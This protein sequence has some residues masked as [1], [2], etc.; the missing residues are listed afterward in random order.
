MNVVKS[1]VEAAMRNRQIVFMVT[2]LLIILG[3]FALLHMPRQEFPVFTIRQGLVIAAYP[4]ATAEQ[5]AQQLTPE[6][7]R[8]LFSYKEVN[9]R[10]TYSYSRDGLMIIFVELNDNV[11]NADEFWSKL[12]H[13]LNL[14][15]AQ[16]PAG[17][18]ALYADNDFGDT[19]ALL[20]S[21]EGDHSSY[22]ELET[23]LNQLEDRLR[24]IE[25]VSKLRHYGLQQ[26]QISIYLDKSKLEK[27]GISTSTITAGLF[28]QGLTASSASINTGATEIPIHLSAVYKTEADIAN[29][30]VY[31]DPAGTLVRIKD[32]A[33]VVREYP[34]PD[35]Y[36]EN[37]AHKSLLISME[38]LE[39]QNIVAYGQEVDE[40]LNDFKQHLP[41]GI[42]IERIAD[43]PKVVKE[44]VS[45]FLFELLFA[46]LSVILVT[47]ILLPFRVASVAASSIPITI[48]ISLG[49]MFVFGIELNTVTLAA[50]IVVL[51]M[52]VDNSIVIVDSYMEKID[53]GMSRWSAAISSANIYVK[54]IV[55]ATLAISITFFPFL[56]TLKGTF[57]DFVEMFPWTVTLTLG[58][59]LLV[60]IMVIPY[61]EY[62]FIRKGFSKKAQAREDRFNMLTYIQRTYEKYLEKAFEKPN[63]TLFMGLL[64]LALAAV[65]F[66]IIPQ[67]LMPV[68]ERNQFAVEIYLPQGSSL[69]KTAMITDSLESLLK[70]D[71]RITSVTS[72][73]GT[74]SPRFH[75]TYAPKIPAKNYAQLIVNTTSNKDTEA[76]LNDYS[77]KYANYFPEAYVRFKQLDYQPVPAPVEI[78]FSGENIG[79]LK[80]AGDSLMTALRLLDGL[81]HVHSDYGE[82]QPAM[83][84][85]I[86]PVEANRIGI[87]KTTVATNLAVRY[88]GIPVTTM[89]ENDYPVNVVLKSTS[90]KDDGVDL[91]NEYVRSMI[92]GV[93]VPLRQIA[94]VHAGW[95]EGQ[96]VRR[97]GVPTLTVM[98]DIERGVNI[99]KLF[100]EVKEAVERI[101]LPQGVSIAYGGAYEN[102][103]EYLPGI[104]YG[105]IISIFMIFM[106]LVLHFRKIS[107]A[108]LVL[109]SSVLSLPGAF[110]GVLLVNVEFG[111]TSILGIV[112]LIGIL[113][114]NGIIMLDYAEELRKEKNMSVKDAAMEAGKRRMRPIFLTS[115]AASVG[116]IAMIVSA[117]PLWS[118]MGAV[119]CFGTI[120]SMVLL[121]LILPVSY[122]RLYDRE[123]T[124]TRRAA[125]KAKSIKPLALVLTGT[126]LLGGSL[127][128]PAQDTLSL[129][130]CRMLA[131]ENNTTLKNAYL[132]IEASEQLKKSAFTN[133]FPKVSAS[134]MTFGFNKPLLDL[135]L[136]GGQLPVF[137]T[138]GITPPVQVPGQFAYFPGLSLSMMDKGTVGAI[139]AIQPVFA[140]GR[141][142]AGNKL[143]RVGLHVNYSKLSLSKDQV[144]A[145]TEEQYWQIISLYEKRKTLDLTKQLLDSLYNEAEDAWKAG[146]VNRNEVLKVALKQSEVR[147][148]ELKLSNGIQ[149]ATMAFC[150]F[151]GLPTDTAL[152][153]A[154]SL[155][156]LR[157]PG[158]VYIDSQDALLNRHEY[159]MLQ[160]SIRAEALKTKLK[161]GE[162]LPQAGVGA[163]ALYYDFPN[164]GTTNTMLFGTVN[165]PISGWWD[166]A[167]SLKERKLREEINR[168]NCE[169]KT[170]LMALQIQQAWND[171]NEAWEQI[172]LARE[173]LRQ[174]E[175]NLAINRDNYQA[176]LINISAMLEAQAMLQQSL[177][178][179]T[180]ARFSYST[181]L[182]AYLQVTGRSSSN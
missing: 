74:S 167:H 16:L 44:S 9:K 181:R 8:Y 154:D 137:A 170:E 173:T 7:E 151:L 109:G 127:T 108:L 77:G 131:L 176:G 111:I 174:A 36:I 182:T 158:E 103:E 165:V 52:I 67:R 150:Q 119:I 113:V 90:A 12:K 135:N 4:G 122:W 163:G 27:Y 98:A 75:T 47:M 136:E 132:E 71:Q 76:L 69:N 164:D 134:A 26:E 178:Q 45:A 130:Q 177:N 88:N 128:L 53:H 70:T 56:F 80:V 25:S 179:V 82:M 156:L 147:Q 2:I 3:V 49:L 21:L 161:R 14:L 118:P 64:A 121:V 96:V 32:I 168:N 93:S 87:D 145:K 41:E 63:R 112:S 140:G 162:Y 124:S 15:K 17:V 22:R 29:Q 84:V 23:Y 92:P 102:D 66:M 86:N 155:P 40:V 89:W 169:E 172:D 62:F 175:E 72:F 68:A 24:R 116:V 61:L 55:S 180:D 106:I 59:S 50:L 43:Q 141:I 125:H 117:N 120:T 13:G 20:I 31:A 159:K 97:N 51:G 10:K 58:I 101:S 19:S 6:V 94:T 152:V 79:D 57:K 126:L 34:E 38:M 30:I 83:R 153:L 46:I 146:L 39:G 65:L 143:A 144:M 11:N 107:M 110:L 81:C 35:S 54:A 73:V 160:E 99:N 123:D 114:R 1:F 78:R 42:T 5:V 139:T 105:L 95:N 142:I 91:L 100:P 148:N 138:D 48:F 28:T 133:Y 149:L 37:N 60:A 85:D 104:I 171:L 166:A 115:A 18:I 157:T 33:T 129:D